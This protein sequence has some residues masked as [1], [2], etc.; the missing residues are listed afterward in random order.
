M[1]LFS[2]LASTTLIALAAGLPR[3]QEPGEPDDGFFVSARV[4]RFSDRA[5][6]NVISE[7]VYRSPIPALGTTSFSESHD[8][9]LA[10]SVIL[11]ALAP[12]CTLLEGA[13]GFPARFGNFQPILVNSEADTCFTA[14]RQINNGQILQ[15]NFDKTNIDCV[16]Q[17]H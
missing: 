15:L 14:V 1:R 2:I 12:G 11:T 7:T 6:Q 5:C 3:P 4:L 13:A 8:E 10:G 16:N 17:N 9:P